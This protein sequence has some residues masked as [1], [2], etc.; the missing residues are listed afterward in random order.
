MQA[1]TPLNFTWAFN[2]IGNAT[3]IHDGKVLQNCKSPLMVP[4]S[5]NI[6]PSDDNSQS[7]GWSHFVQVK[8]TDVCGYTTSATYAYDSRKISVQGQL[9]DCY[10]AW[11]FAQDV[12]RLVADGKV[13]PNSSWQAGVENFTADASANNGAA[14]SSTTTPNGAATALPARAVFTVV[15][16]VLVVLVAGL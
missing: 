6:T 16:A 10:T 15:L 13:D 7:G 4:A 1:G 9:L 14:N 12:K 11:N 8:F 2:G 5:D 3:C